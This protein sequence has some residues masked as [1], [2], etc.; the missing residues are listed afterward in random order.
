MFPILVSE[1]LLPEHIRLG[2]LADFPEPTWE[3]WHRYDNGKLATKHDLHIPSQ[4]KMA[5]HDIAR[6]VEPFPGS[7]WD[8][9]FHGSGLHLMPEG[10]DLGFHTDA[11]FHPTKPWR[12]VAS[13]VYFLETTSGGELIIDGRKHNPIQNRAIMFKADLRHGVQQT[14]Q[15]RR[16]LSL[17]A[18]TR[19][20]GTKTTT[21]AQFESSGSQFDQRA[22]SIQE[23][24]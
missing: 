10:C 3:H 11:E 23:S 2:A 17:F 5:L 15:R 16:T 14:T 7:F 21:R 20:S 9:T 13:L 4:C 6:R 1:N 22:W 8:L 19:D 18:W 12:R 24:C